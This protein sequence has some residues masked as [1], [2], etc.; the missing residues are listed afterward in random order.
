[1]PIGYLFSFTARHE[2]TDL[3][4]PQPSLSPAHAPYALA[5]I[6]AAASFW[7]QVA[8]DPR[9]SPTFQSLALAH[10]ER[11]AGLRA[12]AALLPG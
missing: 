7:A 12:F 5:A 6:D 2:L 1:M 11:V 9:I 8:S 10:T 3:P 4:C